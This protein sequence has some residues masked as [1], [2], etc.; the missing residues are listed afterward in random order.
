MKQIDL[1]E[2]LPYEAPEEVPAEELD[3][4]DETEVNSESTDTETKPNISS[5]SKYPNDSKDDEDNS[6]SGNV[7]DKGQATL[8]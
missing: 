4:V 2:P 1:L 7:D 6:N 3:V 8:F 5:T